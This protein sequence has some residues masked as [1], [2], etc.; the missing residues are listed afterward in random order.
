MQ[1]DLWPPHYRVGPGETGVKARMVRDR[2]DGGGR[3]GPVDRRDD[4]RGGRGRDR[5]GGDDGGRGADGG[6]DRDRRYSGTHLT[7]EL[8]S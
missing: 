6:G 1:D 5:E 2:G 7:C 8:H 4:R 3:G